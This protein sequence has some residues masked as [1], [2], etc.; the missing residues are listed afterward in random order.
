VTTQLMDQFPNNTIVYY[1]DCP[2]CAALFRPY[3]SARR[4]GEKFNLLNA[5]EIPG[6]RES[7]K[8]GLGI[9]LNRD[10]ALYLNGQWHA[11]GEAVALLYCA[12]IRSR[13]L[14][15]PASALVRAVYPV[16]RLGRRTLL[17][18]SDATS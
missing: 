5:R 14:R 3:S 1:G 8:R 4:R 13:Q 7:M 2:V 11:G 18:R 16:L 17:K 10:M 12:G 6:I 15:N 9:D